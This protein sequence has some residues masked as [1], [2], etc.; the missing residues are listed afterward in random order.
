MSFIENGSVIGRTIQDAYHSSLKDQVNAGVL[1][2]ASYVGVE[3]WF[4]SIKGNKQASEPERQVEP[5][6]S[7]TGLND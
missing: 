4:K 5:N 3:A 6:L 7:T 1:P 2:A